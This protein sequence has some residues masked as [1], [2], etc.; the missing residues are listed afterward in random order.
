MGSEQG[1]I[2]YFT[3]IDNNLEGT[4]TESD[5]LNKLLDTANVSFDRGMRTGAT[6]CNLYEDSNTEMII[7]NYSGG[8]E[9]FN[10]NVNVL[11]D[12]FTEIGFAEL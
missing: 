4:Y 10:G 9:Y 12:N 5:Q 1:V 8:L 2:Y 3:D 6:I 7:G 11:Y